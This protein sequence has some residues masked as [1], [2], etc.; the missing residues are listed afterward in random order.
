[1]PAEELLREK[2]RSSFGSLI[3]GAVELLERDAALPPRCKAGIRYILVD[4]FS[5]YEHRTASLLELL[6]NNRKEYP[7]VGDTTG[8]YR[9]RG[10]SFGQL[11]TLSW[12]VSPDG[13]RRRF[14]A[15]SCPS[16]RL[17]VELFYSKYFFLHLLFPDAIF[18]KYCIVY[19]VII[20]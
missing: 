2:K 1:M 13:G 3:T 11:Q 5:G 16:L 4:E 7:A 6:A 20:F 14:R 12:S 15:V 19:I 17:Y 8:I 18:Q 10:A 9:F